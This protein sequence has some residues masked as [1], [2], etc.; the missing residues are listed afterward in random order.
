MPNHIIGDSRLVRDLRARIE[1]VAKT[2][3]RVLILGENGSG[4]ELIAEALHAGS[5]R[6]RAPFVTVNCA[7][8]P[9]TLFESELFG[10]EKGAF[11]GA[12]C[13]R[14]G[15][16][17]Q[18]RGGTIF[19]DEI[20][21]MPFVTQS[22]ILRVLQ[23]GTFQR[24]GG[25]TT[26]KTDVRVIAATNRDLRSATHAGG[27]R[28][29]LYH[30]LA[31]IVL[32]SPALR[33][34]LEDIPDLVRH[35][36]SL[37]ARPTLVVSNEA[38]RVLMRHEYT[39]NVRE[40]ANI[41]ERVVVLAETM[42]VNADFVRE[43]IAM[44]LEYPHATLTQAQSSESVDSRIDVLTRQVQ[45]LVDAFEAH[46][47][48]VLKN[49]RQ[50]PVEPAASADPFAEDESLCRQKR[51]DEEGAE[52]ASMTALGDTALRPPVE[53]VEECL[54]HRKDGDTDY[55][56][57]VVQRKP[58][59]GRRISSAIEHALLAVTMEHPTWGQVR[60]AADLVR[61]GMSIS[62]AGIRLV[63][64]R[65]GLQTTNQ[66][67]AWAARQEK[68]VTVEEEEETAMEVVPSLPVLTLAPSVGD[69]VIHVDGRRGL[70]ADMQDG[71]VLVD[72]LSSDAAFPVKTTEQ[73]LWEPHEWTS[74]DTTS[75]T[76]R[77][78]RPSPVPHNSDVTSNTRYGS[79]S[80]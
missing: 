67:L 53:G 59:H 22:K 30:R 5:G 16:F 73:A 55:A 44:N 25:K 49:A 51:D 60:V 71:V 2:D 32:R 76:S 31:V 69:T 7:A 48:V 10:H 56:E 3:A 1:R 72:L 41:I 11:T 54:S 36:I 17:E 80:A 39:G 28:E 29:D 42:E 34:R 26:L 40:L 75:G 47:Y 18:A 66:R 15:R 45:R 35:F 50:A 63:W 58:R 62:P 61:R 78:R 79:V 38:L 70:I 8:I 12:T 14:E 6:A 19:L 37:S 27:F 9:D 13:A 20:G 24:V 65:N 68:S 57:V 52:N 64:L 33:M 23:N 4:K 74:L 46:T 43:V 21:D 77:S